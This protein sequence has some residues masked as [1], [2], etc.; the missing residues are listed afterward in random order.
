VMLEGPQG[1]QQEIHQAT[2]HNE[3]GAGANNLVKTNEDFSGNFT[4]IVANG[5]WYLRVQD[6]LAGDIA[7]FKSFML[8]IATDD[9]VT[10]PSP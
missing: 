4:G 2:I 9:V 6:R 8:E 3:G 10:P 1:F 5:D 7:T